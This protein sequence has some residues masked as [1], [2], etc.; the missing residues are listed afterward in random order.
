MTYDRPDLTSPGNIAGAV[1][2]L[3]LFIVFMPFLAIFLPIAIAILIALYLMSARAEKSSRA[4]A[5]KRMHG[6]ESKLEIE[7]SG[8]A[9][10]DWGVF[11]GAF[12]K[13]TVEMSWDEIT[14]VSEPAIGVLEFR[15]SK[16]PAITVD[17]GQDR[18]FEVIWGVH[19][20]IPNR[21]EFLL[22]PATG[23]LTLLGRLRRQVEFRG[24]WGS[25]VFTNEAM[26]HN[27]VI[28]MW[29]E[30]TSVSEE[31]FPGIENE[32]NPYWVLAVRSGRHS[33]ELSSTSFC[34]G[35]MLWDTDY[36]LIKSIIAQ[37][38]P[39]KFSYQRRVPTGRVRACDEYNRCREATRA[40]FTLALK[41]GIFTPCEKFFRHM[42]ALVDRFGLEGSCDTLTLYQDYAEL[43]DRTNRP[44]EA[45]HMHERARRTAKGS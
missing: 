45:A 6:A 37:K 18:Y 23:E 15:S 41:S 4:A 34:D 44:R 24:R 31:Y 28:M 42:T 22:D 27:G 38:L 12:G 5:R 26:Q 1:I 11:Y 43:L 36:D 33:F 9:L 13:S 39:D 32:T 10:N 7:A 35:P 25:L 29:P 21:T 40:A 16:G 8:L 17:L 14:L 19:S 3:V 2:V 20:M 30:I